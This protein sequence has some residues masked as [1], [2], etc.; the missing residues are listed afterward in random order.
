[1]YKTNFSEVQNHGNH[2]L[3]SLDINI[4]TQI[5]ANVNKYCC[6]KGIETRK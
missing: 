4:I 5:K 3:S 1:M 6:N 2:S